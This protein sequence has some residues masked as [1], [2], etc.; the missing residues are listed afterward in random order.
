M[1]VQEGVRIKLLARVPDHIHDD[2]G[3]HVAVDHQCVVQD[4]TY[5]GRVFNVKG[6]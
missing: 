1:Q 3:Y 5:V 4:K 6:R 2:I